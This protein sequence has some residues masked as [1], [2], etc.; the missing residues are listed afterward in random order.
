MN[1]KG[2]IHIDKVIKFLLVGMVIVLV[3]WTLFKVNIPGMGEFLPNFG[4]SEKDNVIENPEFP[5]IIEGKKVCCCFNENNVNTGNCKIVD[6]ENGKY[7][8]DSLG[9]FWISAPTDDYCFFEKI[10]Q[11]GFDD[12][13]DGK[14]DCAD[15][16]CDKKSCGGE[17]ICVGG[18]CSFVIEGKVVKEEQIPVGTII[19]I[20]GFEDKIEVF[21]ISEKVGVKLFPNGNLIQN[22]LTYSK[23][24]PIFSEDKMNKIYEED[25][26]KI[27]ML[28]DAKSKEELANKMVDIAGTE[29]AEFLE[30]KSEIVKQIISERMGTKL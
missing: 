21:W 28:F 15:E 17:K 16:D 5:R 4:N 11:Y 13:E 30:P 29:R 27:K 7:C 3:L 18:E 12:D 19:F 22:A 1:R 8:R 10:C 24:D 2:A 14:I 20:K 6:V 25:I 26:L 9:E 23:E